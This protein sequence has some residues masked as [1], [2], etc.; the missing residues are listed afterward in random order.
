[1]S[2]TSTA[3]NLTNT[4]IGGPFIFTNTATT[5][6]YLLSLHDALPISVDNQGTVL[7][8]GSS[9]L[10]GP[11]TT[12]TGSLIHIE[13]NGRISAAF[14]TVA[15]AFTNSGTIELTSLHNSYGASLTVNAGTLNNVGIIQ[16]L[17]GAGAGGGRT[18]NARSEEHTSELQSHS[19]I[20]C[21]LS[22]DNKNSGTIDA[23]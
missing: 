7:V 16:A 9:T 14:L 3:S 18:L 1:M 21:R 6:L 17:V 20:V 12:V 19:E 15:S 2:T 13:G 8:H 10:N 5:T 11:L 22:P 4:P 23:S